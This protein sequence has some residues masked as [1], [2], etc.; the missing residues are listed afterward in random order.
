MVM[1]LEFNVLWHRSATWGDVVIYNY[2]N[3]IWMYST[4]IMSARVQEIANN[5]SHLREIIV[6][7][8]VQQ[9]QR[10]TSSVSVSGAV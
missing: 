6:F 3:H 2:V 4:E 9:I 5:I 10:K 1:K 7:F 8:F